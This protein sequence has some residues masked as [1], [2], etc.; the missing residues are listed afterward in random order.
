VANYNLLFGGNIELF[1][2]PPC[3]KIMTFCYLKVADSGGR[4]I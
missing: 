2:E 1:Y 3:K 4:A